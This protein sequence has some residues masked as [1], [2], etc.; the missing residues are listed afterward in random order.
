MQT[1]VD[2]ESDALLQ[3]EVAACLRVGDLV[4][5]FIW[6]AI[7]LISVFEPLD[8]FV[9]RRDQTIDVDIRLLPDS[10]TAPMLEGHPALSQLH[11][12]GRRWRDAGS[13]SRLS[14]ESGLFKALKARGY[15][16]IVHL[17]RLRDDV[18]GDLRPLNA[19]SLSNAAPIEAITAVLLQLNVRYKTRAA[20]RLTGINLDK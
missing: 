3:R 1:R 4:G 15:D 2:P 16:L 14:L 13:F 5:G 10:D 11:L 9:I 6:P 7:W 12:V 18:I 19:G 8:L 20:L 17:T